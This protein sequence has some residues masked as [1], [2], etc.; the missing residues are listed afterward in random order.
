MGVEDGHIFDLGD[1]YEVEL[2]MLPGHS[3]G[4]SGYYDHHNHIIFTG[5]TAGICDAV[6][7]S[8]ILRTARWKRCGTP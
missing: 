5:D 6:P 1:G 4:Q 8:L 7:G 2:V 3:P